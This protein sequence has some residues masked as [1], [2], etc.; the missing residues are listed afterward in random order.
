MKH[1]FKFNNF[2]KKNVKTRT[3]RNRKHKY[4]YYNRQKFTKKFSFISKMKMIWD[5]V[6][7]TSFVNRLV[8]G[9]FKTT[10]KPFYYISEDIHKTLTI[11]DFLIFDKYWSRFSR[12][13]QE[14]LPLWNF[15]GFDKDLLALKCAWDQRTTDGLYFS[16]KLEQA[17]RNWF[18][19][20]FLFW[21]TSIST[22]I[23]K[24]NFF[25]YIF[26]FILM[27]VLSLNYFSLFFTMDMN[28]HGFFAWFDSFI[29]KQSWY[30]ADSNANTAY[31]L[32]LYNI[33]W[34]S[35]F[36]YS[37]FG[38]GFW[39]INSSYYNY[40]DSWFYINLNLQHLWFM[41]LSKFFDNHVLGILLQ[42]KSTNSVNFFDFYSRFVWRILDLF[43][44][45]YFVNGL[46]ESFYDFY[47]SIRYDLLYEI[48]PEYVLIDYRPYVIESTWFY[49]NKYIWFITSH[50]D[51]YFRQWLFVILNDLEWFRDSLPSMIKNF[52]WFKKKWLTSKI[53]IYYINKY[54]FLLWDYSLISLKAVFYFCY[55]LLLIDQLVS[56]VTYFLKL[57]YIYQI[58]VFIF[59]PVLFVYNWFLDFFFYSWTTAFSQGFFFNYL[60]K[61]IIHDFLFFWLELSDIPFFR[62]F[63]FMRRHTMSYMYNWYVFFPTILNTFSQ[64]WSL[65]LYYIPVYGYWTSVN[66]II[67]SLQFLTSLIFED[68][69]IKP[70]NV[71]LEWLYT[72]MG[73]FFVFEHE[74]NI[75]REW[76]INFR[77]NL[78]L[79]NNSWF[80][81]ISFEIFAT[82]QT[83]ML[84]FLYEQQNFSQHWVDYFAE[85]Y[86]FTHYSD[87][88]GVEEVVIKYPFDDQR[89]FIKFINTFMGDLLLFVIFSL[90]L[91][92]NQ[93]SVLDFSFLSHFRAFFFAGWGHSFENETIQIMYRNWLYWQSTVF[94]YSFDR[95]FVVYQEFQLQLVKKHLFASFFKQTFPET[96][97]IFDQYISQN[98]FYI[99]IHDLYIDATWELWNS[100]DFGRLNFSFFEFFDWDT[101]SSNYSKLR[102]DPDRLSIPW[103]FDF[104]DVMEAYPHHL[105]TILGILHDYNV[106]REFGIHKPDSVL[107]GAG[108]VEAFTE[109]IMEAEFD[110]P[111]R[112]PLHSHY[113]LLGLIHTFWLYSYDLIR[114]YELSMGYVIAS[115][116]FIWTVGG[117]DPKMTEVLDINLE[118]FP[119][120]KDYEGWSRLKNNFDFDFYYAQAMKYYDNISF[121]PRPYAKMSTDWMLVD[122]LYQEKWP[123]LQESKFSYAIIPALNSFDEYWR[124]MSYYDGSFNILYW[125][126]RDSFF[127][128]PLI[129]TIFIAWRDFFILGVPISVLTTEFMPFSLYNTSWSPMILKHFFELLLIVFYACQVIIQFFLSIISGNAESLVVLYMIFFSEYALISHDNL[130]IQLFFKFF[131]WFYDISLFISNNMIFWVS[132]KTSKL[133][134]GF[135]K[136]SGFIDDFKKQFEFFVA[137]SEYK[138]YTKVLKLKTSVYLQQIAPFFSIYD[139]YVD[140]NFSKIHEA[141]IKDNWIELK[142][143]AYIRGFKKTASALHR[144]VPLFPDLYNLSDNLVQT[145]M[146]KLLNHLTYWVEY[147]KENVF[148]WVDWYSER[149][150]NNSHYRDKFA[151]TMPF[152]NI[153]SE[154]YYSQKNLHFDSTNFPVLLQL[155]VLEHPILMEYKK[156]GRL[157]KMQEGGIGYLGEIYVREWRT[158]SAFQA[159]YTGQGNAFGVVNLR[160]QRIFGFWY[161]F[162]YFFA[163]VCFLFVFITIWTTRSFWSSLYPLF[164]PWRSIVL[165]R[166]PRLG[167]Q[168]LHDNRDDIALRPI[169]DN[170][171]LFFDVAYF[172]H[173]S[174]DYIYLPYRQFAFE[175]WNQKP[176]WYFLEN[177]ALDMSFDMFFD[178]G[179]P[180]KE[181]KKKRGYYKKLNKEW[182]LIMN[183][184]KRL[185]K[186]KPNFY[187]KQELRFFPLLDYWFEHK[188]LLKEEYKPEYKLHVTTVFFL[189]TLAIYSTCF[190]YIIK[191]WVFSWLFVKPDFFFE[192][193]W[194]SLLVKLLPTSFE[195]VSGLI[196]VFCL[197]FFWIV[198]L[199]LVAWFRILWEDFSQLTGN[200]LNFFGLLWICLIFNVLS[201]ARYW[202]GKLLSSRFLH[203]VS[204]YCFIDHKWRV[205]Y[206]IEGKDN[207]DLDIIFGVDLTSWFE[208]NG[209]A[210][211]EIIEI[212]QRNTT[213]GLSPLYNKSMLNADLL[214]NALFLQDL[215]ISTLDNSLNFVDVE[216]NKMFINIM[217]RP[218][219]LIAAAK[220]LPMRDENIQ[221]N[222]D[223]HGLLSTKDLDLFFFN[224]NVTKKFNYNF[225]VSKK[226]LNSY[227]FINQNGFYF[228]IFLSL[229]LFAKYQKDSSSFIFIDTQL[230]LINNDPSLI[231]TKRGLYDDWNLSTGLYQ[232]DWS[233]RKFLQDFFS[234]WEDIQMEQDHV[235][236]L[237]RKDIK[238]FLNFQ[239]KN[240]P[241]LITFEKMPWI[242]E[243]F[244]NPFS[245]APWVKAPS[246]LLWPLGGVKPTMPESIT[247]EWRDP[248][249][250][251]GLCDDFLAYRE[252]LDRSTSSIGTD[253]AWGFIDIMDKV[254]KENQEFFFRKE[255][256]KRLH[257]EKLER[258]AIKEMWSDFDISLSEP[259][260]TNDI[261]QIDSELDPSVYR[262]FF[263]GLEDKRANVMP[264]NSYSKLS[265]LENPRDFQLFDAYDEDY[266]FN[267]DFGFDYYNLE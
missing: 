38:D 127:A 129:Y 115:G 193:F 117:F 76:F 179:K 177:N 130:N 172:Y 95:M 51:N 113:N 178:L 200:F 15:G 157:V 106:L 69:P 73:P 39:T 170:A 26:M 234:I 195:F 258:L 90:N 262:H 49:L 78:L 108:L 27:V 246:R 176:G 45:P 219:A 162:D 85:I 17:R 58:L 123:L 5:K 187:F 31:Y 173:Q 103:F 185:V 10:R 254:G 40:V 252:I 19:T 109:G 133:F 62:D 46:S 53:Y 174:A 94:K 136:T 3:L 214:N 155:H 23:I 243:L 248:D 67:Y 119:Y 226:F 74:S 120:F 251:L 37:F 267:L 171:D 43:V 249:V 20:R 93:T 150:F 116:N 220:I 223:K 232:A 61:D 264:Y 230:N 148:K 83:D 55:K 190:E 204:G 47:I 236:F 146:V 238:K 6:Y 168:H 33:Q 91:L 184:T 128:A 100:F 247:H 256:Y 139:V 198:A 231:S 260:I 16:T 160:V 99:N 41:G 36:S 263:L 12:L 147:Y 11:S 151:T 239:K 70:I 124:F 9:D 183:T 163:I 245:S 112:S 88:M 210:G 240:K 141:A 217:A 7:Y 110:H 261:W 235:S 222:F 25:W 2:T 77:D 140:F 66:L 186:K 167:F 57:L 126:L 196:T 218:G 44:I 122:N 32:L 104:R 203:K 8:R 244:Q 80:G 105:F 30:L 175:S 107:A 98:N 156:L 4:I 225:E 237:N 56:F 97:D 137:Y 92:T 144:F 28:L 257:E 265:A 224:S 132:V 242:V 63:F 118:E 13:S 159:Y 192:T 199:Y 205:N 52:H 191:S 188:R 253:Q 111:Q 221:S 197:Y 250:F 121:F 35:N 131:I 158:S 134:T 149:A 125:K 169:E 241:K 194:T 202:T 135:H 54:I 255:F 164:D 1:Q 165:I 89:H 152:F 114:V 215:R 72:H 211:S 216:S 145:E 60:Y 182:A 81:G 96:F 24:L 82:D 14:K 138:R 84:F 64:T 181:K 79:H 50:Y 201:S 65:V 266:V 212:H 29:D 87:F 143:N 259:A 68:Y 229:D 48:F 209:G 101:F 233:S 75:I 102:E 59:K 227:G 34:I 213:M 207:E 206:K 161:V 189:I 153:L 42:I 71:D 180:Y 21:T 142:D 22:Y 228:R 166:Y 154:V 18:S 86:F 208:T